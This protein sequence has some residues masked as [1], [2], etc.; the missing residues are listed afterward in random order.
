M[1]PVYVSSSIGIF[2]YPKTE[3]AHLTHGKLWDDEHEL[4]GKTVFPHQRE[5]IKQILAEELLGSGINC[6]VYD[7]AEVFS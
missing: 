3:L 6:Y 7:E 5:R 4:L 1:K 2:I